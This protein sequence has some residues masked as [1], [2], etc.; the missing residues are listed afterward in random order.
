MSARNQKKLFEQVHDLKTD[1]FKLH[2]LR[3]F[4]A[5]LA[6]QHPHST[7]SEMSA[8]PVKAFCIFLLLVCLATSALELNRATLSPPG[9]VEKGKKLAFTKLI[10][11][12]LP[13]LT[14][15]PIRCFKFRS[16]QKKVADET[17]HYVRIQL[18]N[19]ECMVV[20]IAESPPSQG[21]KLKLKAAK[22]SGCY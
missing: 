6:N 14:G 16:A 21:R 3:I 7:Y 10:I 9:R 19:G 15:K 20:E 22:P 2:V 8:S 18:F 1:S 17:T 12:G 11:T 5:E 13:A 4:W